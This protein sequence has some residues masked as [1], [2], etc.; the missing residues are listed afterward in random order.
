MKSSSINILVLHGP[1]LNLLGEREPEI[2][3]AM[4][5][6]ELNLKIKAF[7]KNKNCRLKIFQSNHEGVL[8]DLLHANRKWAT[9]VIFNPAG[10]TH[11]SVA[12]G[13]AVLAIG[14][15]T[16]EVHLSDIQKR[17]KFRKISYIAP[18][19]VKQFSGLGFKSYL[20]ALEYFLKKAK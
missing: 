10:L 12:L 13:D 8:I 17:E 2:Y 19:C 1:N 15:P 4:T 6:P 14:V 7:V 20:K 18:V 3:G 16:I 9:G 5:L 11:T